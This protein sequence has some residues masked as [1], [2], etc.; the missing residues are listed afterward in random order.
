MSV[1][2]NLLLRKLSIAHNTVSADFLSSVDA[3]R[4]NFMPYYSSCSISCGNNQP[5]PI[6]VAYLS[7]SYSV[8][9]IKQVLFLFS[10]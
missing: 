9:P 3:Y 1:R 2:E 5:S 10:I 8:R 7:V 6:S 4:L